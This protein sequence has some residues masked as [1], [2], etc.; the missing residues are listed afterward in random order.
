K[1]SEG[2]IQLEN[3]LQYK[4]LKTA[5]GNPPQNGDRVKIHVQGKH[6]DGNIFE[7]TFELKT[8]VTVTVG[9]TLRGLDEALRRMP[10]GEKW[11][12]FIPANLGFGQRGSPP[13]V[14]P[15]ETLIYEVELLEILG[16]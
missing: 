2:V 7:N 16:K 6:V 14:G 4:V 1:L 3:G 13:L 9:T 12:L 11:E 10:A 5:K 8:P 15:N